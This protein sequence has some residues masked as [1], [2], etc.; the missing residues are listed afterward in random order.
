MGAKKLVLV[1]R[2]RNRQPDVRTDMRLNETHHFVPS[3]GDEKRCRHC[4]GYP[5]DLLHWCI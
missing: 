1:G 3:E 2:S 4:G 5:F